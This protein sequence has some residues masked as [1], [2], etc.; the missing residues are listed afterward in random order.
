MEDPGTWRLDELMRV[1]T[2]RISAQMCCLNTSPLSYPLSHTLK[3]KKKKPEKQIQ[4]K[5]S[6]QVLF[7]IFFN[8][9]FL[10]KTQKEYRNDVLT[11]RC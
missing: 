10:T 7:Q 1:S 8:Q 9:Q 6:D 5:L 2:V 4:Q 11:K 3:K